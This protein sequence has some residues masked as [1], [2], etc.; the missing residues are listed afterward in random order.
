MSALILFL[1]RISEA[2]ERLGPPQSQAMDFSQAHAFVWDAGLLDFKP[3][4]QIQSLPLSLLIGVDE[5]SRI[6]LS[7]TLRFAEGFG[8]NNALL[9]GARGAGKSSLVKAVHAEILKRAR[10]NEQLLPLKLIEIH[11]DDLQTLTVLMRELRGLPY[12]FIIFCDD[13]SFEAGDVLYKSLK[14]ALEGGLEGR[15][16]N[17]LFY[18]TSNRRHLLA[19]DMLEN[20]NGSA[21]HP[22][23]VIEEKVSLADRF[24]LWIGFHH[25]DQETYLRMVN[26]YS[27]HFKLPIL[28]EELERE[29]LTWAMVRGSRSGRVAWQFIQD[30]A[31]RLRVKLTT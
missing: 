4:A 31:G 15:P 6:L 18:A 23:D 28:S 17:V 8:A 3:V 10:D 1:Q 16:D 19:R 20:E 24:G 30:L 22:G 29:A 25:A 12:R 26:A 5:A 14:G 9:W 13:L 7:N 2:L 27:K 11:R 21:L